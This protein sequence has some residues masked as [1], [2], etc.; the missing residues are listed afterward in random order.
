M[1]ADPAKNFEISYM[2]PAMRTVAI[3]MGRDLSVPV[4]RLMG[5]SIDIFH[6]NAEHQRRLLSNPANLPWSGRVSLGAKRFSLKVSAITDGAGTYVGPMVTWDDVT[7]R[8]TLAEN[9]KASVSDVIARVG[10]MRDQAAGMATTA[11][12][13]R[14]QSVSVA[15]SAE[16]ATTNVKAV[17][18][19]S[20]E[21]SAT[22]R[23][24]S[25]QINRSSAMAGEASNLAESTKSQADE[26]TIASQRIGDIVGLIS[27][28]AAQ[29]NLLALNATI[30]AARAGEAGKGFAVVANEVKSLASQTSS[31]TAEISSQ[32]AG[33]QGITSRTVAQITS[34][35]NK[36]DD[37]SRLLTSV[38]AATE[39]QGVATQE[40]SRNVQ[41]AAQG[42]MGVSATIADVRDASGATGEAANRLLGVVNELASVSQGMS[43]SADQFLARMRA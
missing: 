22:I 36:I 29:T 38:A 3:S 43:Q 40:I 34:V 9:V 24:I 12:S 33:I 31:A 19:A 25:D 28:I 11:G 39:E 14:E 21:M 26:L 7:E 15:A 1:M 35:T 41:E 37:I 5:T 10:T 8:E 18:A 4:D 16:E 20:E 42:T 32:I 13:T 17:A 27:A 30:E 6:K 23:E 2:N